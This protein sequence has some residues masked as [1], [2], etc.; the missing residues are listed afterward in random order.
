ME[1]DT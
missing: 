1:C